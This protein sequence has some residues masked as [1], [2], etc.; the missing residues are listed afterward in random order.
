MSTFA[1]GLLVARD[2]GADH[3]RGLQDVLQRT[4]AQ[5]VQAQVQPFMK[6]I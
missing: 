1:T 5:A 3:A 6:P 2:E 4:A